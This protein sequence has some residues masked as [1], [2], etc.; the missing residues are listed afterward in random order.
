MRT[1]RVTLKTPH[2][3]T[4]KRLYRPGVYDLPESLAIAWG[5]AQAEATG[6]G[7]VFVP[8]TGMLPPGFPGIDALLAAGCATLE[9]VAALDLEAVKVPGI[10]KATAVKIAEALAANAGTGGE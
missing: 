4:E 5:Y 3:D 2:W 6:T 1:V 7:Y 8:D 9:A 10:G